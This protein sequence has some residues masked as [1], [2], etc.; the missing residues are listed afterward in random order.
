[1]ASTPLQLLDASYDILHRSCPEYPSKSCAFTSAR[2]GAY[3]F[4]IYSVQ[5]LLRA[6]I[7]CGV[8]RS[9]LDCGQPRTSGNP[10]ER[11]KQCLWLPCPWKP[12]HSHSL[13]ILIPQPGIRLLHKTQ[14][15]GGDRH[16]ASYTGHT[17]D[18]RFSRAVEWLCLLWDGLEQTD[19]F[20][21]PGS[22]DTVRNHL[23]MD[24]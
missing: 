3:N 12:S 10:Y 22:N 8:K 14:E 18:G 15:G 13:G 5:W 7:R 1:M 9:N 20:S 4:S 2:D 17:A 24:T 19:V 21:Q 23:G 11:R 6:L 16:L